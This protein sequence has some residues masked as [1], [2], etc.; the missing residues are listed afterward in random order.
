V[1][2]FAILACTTAL[3]RA[4]GP[5]KKEAEP[6]QVSYY[7][8][9]RP[10]FQQHC[11]GCHQPARSKGE[12]VLTDFA[13]LMKPGESGEPSVVP[14]QPQKS[15]IVMQITPHGGNRPAM[16]KDHPPLTDYDVG[17]IQKWITQGAKDDTPMSAQ[18]VVVDADHPPIYA[19]PPVITAIDYS[20]DSQLLAV[21]GY[22]EV[23][24]H[25]ADGSGLVAR[26]VGLSER[27]QSLAFSPDGKLLA[28]SGGDPCRFGEVQ[29]WDVEKRKLKLS[30]PVTF[31]TV[32]GV[33][34]SPDGTKI[35]FGCADNTLRAID[36]A[37][38]KQVLYQ[39]AHNDWVLATT[40]STEGDYLVSV[41]RDRSMKLTEVSTQRFIDNITSITPGALKGG[42]LTVARRP[43]G[44]RK[45]VK[46]PPDPREHRYDELL[47]GG[48]D[49][50]PRLYKMHREVKRV[51]GDDANKVRELAPMPGRIFSGRFN[52]DGSRVVVGSSLEGTGEVRVYK[53]GPDG[54]DPRYAWLEGLPMNSTHGLPAVLRAAGAKGIGQMVCKLE[55]QHGAVY[56]VAYRPDGKQVASAGFDGVVRLNDPQTGKLIKEFV[57][58]PLTNA[59]VRAGGNK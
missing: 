35:A 31:D 53:V 12:Y 6:A 56:A 57:P 54:P 29:I 48:S 18:G 21:S 17:L 41:S 39:G 44:Y 45:M 58:V 40:F 28:V 10:L 20:P 7:H 42:L 5:A 43:L 33:S 46:S 9:I 3:G 23:L 55:G 19:L 47:I 50:V 1:Y 51:I 25:K 16:P 36:A 22:H 13:S 24:L 11:Q 26:L 27:I 14:G 4:D 34:W 59:T 49:G 2:T 32:Y 8:H 52:A 38:G 37:T 15:A 30:V